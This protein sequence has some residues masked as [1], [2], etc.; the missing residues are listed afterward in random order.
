MK[1]N[2]ISAQTVQQDKQSD[3]PGFRWRW[4]DL[5]RSNR[6]SDLDEFISIW[7]LNTEVLRFLVCTVCV[8]MYVKILFAYFEL[9]QQAE[10]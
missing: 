8:Y 2:F 3:V 9:S 5:Y 4:T 7:G 10:Q 6:I 1:P